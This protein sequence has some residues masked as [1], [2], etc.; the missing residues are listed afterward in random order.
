[1]F[2]VVHVQEIAAFRNSLL[3]FPVRIQEMAHQAFLTCSADLI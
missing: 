3:I 2:S 1:M